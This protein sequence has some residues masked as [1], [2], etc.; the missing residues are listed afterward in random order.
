MHIGRAHQAL[1]PNALKPSAGRE[2]I[3]VHRAG[4]DTIVVD[5]TLIDH[6]H[7]VGVRAPSASRQVGVTGAKRSEQSSPASRHRSPERV[8]AG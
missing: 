6:M 2:T 8:Q 4:Q 3:E 5:G 1:E 7:S